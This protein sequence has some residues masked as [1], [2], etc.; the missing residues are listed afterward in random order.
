VA[1]SPDGTRAFVSMPRPDARGLLVLS[2][3]A[4]WRLQHA[5]WVD[6]ALVPRGMTMDSAGRHLLAAN[7][8]GGLIVACADALAAG[9]SDPI[10]ALLAAPSTGSMQV[11]LDPEDRFAYVT[12]EQTSTV[13]VFDFER[14]LR[15]PAP[16]ARLVGQARVPAGPVG[17]AL[18]PDGEHL[19]VTSQGSGRRGALSVLRTR[20]A[21]RDPARAV[22]V[23]TPAGSRPVRVAVDSEL[24]WVSARASN[25]LLAFDLR[26]LLRG[27]AR[28]LRA[29]VRV[30]AAPVG[31]AL[32][33][34]GGTVVVANS[35]RYGPDAQRAQTLSVVD[36]QAALKGRRALIGSVPAGAFPRELARLPDDRSVL[37]T[38][39]LSQSL[40]AVSVIG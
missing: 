23:S 19:L 3:G 11:V 20:E 2:P 35:N 26:R 34:G 38:N 31:L 15:S 13:S 33:A 36:A 17:L 28:P 27:A 29:S 22:V 7:S 18:T 10:V 37:V 40:E 4:P 32:L 21:A 12:D 30:G 24:A 25:S 6:P 16:R 9:A 14:S 5:H 1:V 39:V 8:A